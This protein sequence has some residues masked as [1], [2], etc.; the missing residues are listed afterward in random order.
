MGMTGKLQ[1]DRIP[2]HG[3]CK[4]GFMS[5][6]NG[7]FTTSNRSQCFFKTWLALKHIV[8]AG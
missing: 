1:I 7:E 4:V 2:L 3:I 5:K 6:Q 8:Y